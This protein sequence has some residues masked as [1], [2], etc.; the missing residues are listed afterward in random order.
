MTMVAVVRAEDA[1]DLR[2]RFVY[3]GAVFLLLLIPRVSRRPIWITAAIV[4]F[5][6]ALT[7]NILALPAAAADWAA[8]ADGPLACIP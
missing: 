5:T 7:T 4:L 2:P 6:V 8:R 1:V 3:V